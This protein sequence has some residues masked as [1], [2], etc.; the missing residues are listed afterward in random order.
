MNPD[1]PKFTAYALDELDAPERAEIEQLLREN[2]A[3]AAEVEETR[4]FAAQ[5]RARLKAEPAEPL[6]PAQRD[7][8][9]ATLNPGA[10]RNVIAFSRR[11]AGWTALAAS[12]VL[13]VGIALFLP[14]LNTMK[15]PLAVQPL[16]ENPRSA[17]GDGSGVKV[18]LGKELAAMPAP[19]ELNEPAL[20]NPALAV[21][22]APPMPDGD[23]LFATAATPPAMRNS[24]G[25]DVALQLE[26]AT[27]PP[28][29]SASE[30]RL[31]ES[32][33]TVA[34]ARSAM[35]PTNYEP[36]QT[37][38]AGKP[39]EPSGQ[40]Q[41]TPMT[42]AKP[43]AMAGRMGGT[44]RSPQRSMQIAD[45]AARVPYYRGRGISDPAKAPDQQVALGHVL[46]EAPVQEVAELAKVEREV[47]LRQKDAEHDWRYDRGFSNL[48]DEVRPEAPSAESYETVQDNAFFKVADAPL[49]TFS[50]D[51]DTASYA[52]VRRFLNS[53]ALPPKAAVRIEELVNYFHYDYPQPDGDTPFSAAMEVATCPWAP[54]HRLLRV[55][56]HGRDIQRAARPASN[57]VFLIDVSGSMQPENKLPLLKRSLQLMVDQLGE[58]DRVAIVVYAGAAGCVL[59]STTSKEKIRT[60]LDR[61]ESGGST[62]GS[63]GL[64]LAYELADKHFIKGG[65]NRVILATDGDWN[66]G[67]TDKG[68]LW[69]IIER[70][71]KSGVFLTVLGFGMDNLKDD[72]LEKLADKGNGNYAYIDTL[73]EGRK[74]LVDELGATLVT[75]AKD[76]KIQIEFNPA[77]V[78][79]YRLIGYENRVMAAKDFND[80]TKDAGEIGAGHSVTAFY[81]LIPAGQPMPAPSVEPLKYQPTIATAEP[82]PEA[83]NQKPETN[84]E[85]LTLKLRY[86]A[87]DADTST[88]REFP[89]KDSGNS[90][91]NS[92]RDFRF[93]ASVAGYGMLLRQSPH[94]GSANWALVHELATEGKGEDRDGYRAEFIGL[95]EKARAL[96]R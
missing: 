68:D 14:A 49:S 32:L 46:Q 19:Q 2:P 23:S 10:P 53:N 43:G 1:D 21:A 84:G 17:A 42:P 89:L 52:N 45:A 11:A 18:M 62:H 36:L 78:G 30:S 63:A 95:V 35:R 20:A 77:Q 66:V 73:N 16:A 59:D 26:I 76:V 22:P 39:V 13:G 33:G 25:K 64:Q 79:A 69:S 24:A 29:S 57:L 61:L 50:I 12:I 82:K 8:V 67:V 80:D 87:P 91:A 55:A 72:M 48:D 90:F 47:L 83:K 28:S 81:E 92:S 58:R 44:A 4:A 38:L 15:K 41:P 31:P 88:L 7:E 74:V 86:K 96:T 40:L 54:E 93:A 60:A 71:A 56:L 70:K 34:L 27:I 9:L 75:I 6:R 85:L 37:A 65:T 5:L 3:A 51:V 94:K